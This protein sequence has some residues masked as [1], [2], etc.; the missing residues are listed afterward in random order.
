MDEA[1]ARAALNGLGG[2][3]GL[4][5]VHGRLRGAFGDGYGLELESAPGSGTT[6]VMTIPKFRAGVRAA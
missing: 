5:N 6:V 1:Q 2:G 4:S 3:I